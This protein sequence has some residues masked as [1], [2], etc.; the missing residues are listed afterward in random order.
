MKRVF[1]VHG[2][3]GFPENHWFPWLKKQLQDAGFHVQVPAMPDTEHPK[4]DAWVGKLREIVGAPDQDTYFVGHSLGCITIAHYLEQLPPNAK[5]GGCVFVAGFGGGL[6]YHE[7]T[8]FYAPLPDFVKVKRHTRNF[9]TIF[10]TNDDV[11]PLE[12]GKKFQQQLGAQLIVEENK[13]HFC[14]DEGVTELPSVRD[15]VLEMASR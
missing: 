14:K 12:I 13:G 11:V 6:K 8:P 15:A 3:T 5:V 10:S 4:R 2:W 7:L 9:V 1:I